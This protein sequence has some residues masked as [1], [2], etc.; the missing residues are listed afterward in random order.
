MKH[1]KHFLLG[2]LLVAFSVSIISCDPTQKQLAKE[3]AR[4]EETVKAETDVLKTEIATLK[5][6]LKLAQLKSDLA[7]LNFQ[8]ESIEKPKEFKTQFEQSTEISD[9]S[10]KIESLNAE[11][12]ATQNAVVS[13]TSNNSK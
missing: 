12:L 7:L 10:A 3:K 4:T 5:N 2:I 11:I 6:E 13:T 1:T 8:L 9:L